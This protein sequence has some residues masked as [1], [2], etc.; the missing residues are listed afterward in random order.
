MTAPMVREWAS[1]YAHELRE[2]SASVQGMEQI[3]ADLDAR[4]AALQAVAYSIY[5]RWL[6]PIIR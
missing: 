2:P 6:R 5:R 4:V 3:T 1:L